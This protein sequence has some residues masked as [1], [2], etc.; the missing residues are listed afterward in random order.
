ME[1]AEQIYHSLGAGDSLL[2][3]SLFAGGDYWTERFGP[4]YARFNRQ[5]CLRGARI[6]RVFILRNQTH[7]DQVHAI[8]KQQSEYS[9]VYVALLDKNPLLEREYRDAFVI[10]DEIAADFHFSQNILTSIDLITDPIEIG[11]ITSLLRRIRDNR[12]SRFTV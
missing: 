4:D 2:A 5:A 12:A 6:E 1:I 11:E 7:F 9:N 3:T 8:L 10:N